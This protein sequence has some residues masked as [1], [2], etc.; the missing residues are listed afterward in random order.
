MLMG[1]PQW[2]LEAGLSARHTQHSGRLSSLRQEPLFENEFGRRT[3]SRLEMED[4]AAFPR[5][6]ELL[7]GLSAPLSQCTCLSVA[8][9]I[10]FPLTKEKRHV[11]R[12]SFAWQLAKGSSIPPEKAWPGGHPTVCLGCPCR[13]SPGSLSRKPSRRGLPGSSNPPFSAW[14]LLGRCTLRGIPHPLPVAVLLVVFFLLFYF[15]ATI[16]SLF[17]GSFVQNLVQEHHWEKR[18]SSFI[19]SGS[20]FEADVGDRPQVTQ[21]RVPLPE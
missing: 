10:L 21:V 5:P 15:L 17:R 9:E 16:L 19:S 12:A 3:M 6:S 20:C 1:Q 14:L 7:G 8:Q 13:E 4:K 11:C 2:M 18:R